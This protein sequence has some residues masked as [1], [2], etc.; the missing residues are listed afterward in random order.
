MAEALLLLLAEL[1]KPS[2]QERAPRPVIC[3]LSP[4]MEK[5]ADCTKRVDR[6]LAPHEVE[7]PT[8]RAVNC[9][10]TTAVS[11]TKSWSRSSAG[12]KRGTGEQP[13]TE[14]SEPCSLSCSK[15]R[16]HT[17]P[18]LDSSNALVKEREEVSLMCCKGRRAQGCDIGVL[19]GGREVSLVTACSCRHGER[20][21]EIETEYAKGTTPMRTARKWSIQ[22]GQCTR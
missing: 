15:W 3:R 6:S 2:K 19:R 12:L 13:S 8:T 21:T 1:S 9:S 10:S 17:S 16:R 14:R 11:T 5:L 22:H 4:L 18:R 20:E 7:L